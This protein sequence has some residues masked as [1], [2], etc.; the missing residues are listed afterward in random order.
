MEVISSPNIQLL[1]HLNL[2][3]IESLQFSI[4]KHYL[5]KFDK[6]IYAKGWDNI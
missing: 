5:G 2:W 3:Y 4:S 1:I 6:F